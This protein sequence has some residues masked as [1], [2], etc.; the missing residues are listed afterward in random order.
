MSKHWKT[1]WFSRKNWERNSAFMRGSGFRVYQFFLRT[2][3]IYQNQAIW[4]FKITVMNLKKSHWCPAAGL[5]NVVP[6]THPT[7]VITH[8]PIQTFHALS[9]TLLLLLHSMYIIQSRCCCFFFSRSAPF[10]CKILSLIS[11]FGCCLCMAFS[12]RASIWV[13]L[14]F[15]PPSKVCQS[16][17]GPTT[18]PQW[19]M[20]ENLLGSSS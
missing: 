16:E 4:Y 13:R 11:L 5:V 10:P 18:S 6:N 2:M 15:F 3:V 9:C 20:D 7:L 1:H 19:R 17:Q 14:W 8:N 12:F